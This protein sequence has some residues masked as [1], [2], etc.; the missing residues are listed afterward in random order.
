MKYTLSLSKVN[1]E[2]LPRN[3]RDERRDIVP[4]EEIAI[5]IAGRPVDGQKLG[6]AQFVWE[7]SE[8]LDVVFSQAVPGPEGGGQGAGV[9]PPRFLQTARDGVVI[10]QD[11]RNFALAHDVA[12]FVR[13]GVVT[14][15]IAEVDNFIDPDSVDVIE[16][17]PRGFQIRVTIGNYGVPH[18]RV[19]RSPRR[20]RPPRGRSALLKTDDPL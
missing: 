16:D 8:P 12:A 3:R 14:D 13:V 18:V 6:F 7:I 2:S 17:R 11:S 15:D 5:S 10:A 4:L 20:W 1:C 19:S 9:E